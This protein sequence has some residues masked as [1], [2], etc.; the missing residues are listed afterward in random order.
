MTFAGAT[1]YCTFGRRGSHTLWYSV[2]LC[3]FGMKLIF[4]RVMPACRFHLGLCFL[5]LHFS[6]AA[7]P[8]CMK[9]K[10]ASRRRSVQ[11]RRQAA[12]SMPTLAALIFGSSSF[13]LLQ[14][15]HSADG[16]LPAASATRPLFQV[17]FLTNGP[18]GPLRPNG[19]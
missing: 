10:T 9:A 17:V 8:G 11:L 1:H 2:S 16:R 7:S 18:D 6:S 12:L 5:C 13:Y 19:E 4:D 14:V 15:A 3:W